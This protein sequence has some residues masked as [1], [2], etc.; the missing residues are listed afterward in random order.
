MKSL[1]AVMLASVCALTAGATSAPLLDVERSDMNVIVAYTPTAV[2]ATATRI[3]PA[4]ETTTTAPTTVAPPATTATT[5]TTTAPTTTTI[6]PTTTTTTTI[7]DT[8]TTT[9]P[10]ESPETASTNSAEST[11]LFSSWM[12]RMRR[13]C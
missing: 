12:T 3:A 8:P 7:T 5:T 13:V 4:V 11:M 1:R 6:A 10:T 9:T 2:W